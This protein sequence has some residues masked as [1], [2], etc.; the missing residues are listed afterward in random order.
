MH[1]QTKQPTVEQRAA[2]A[3]E[4]ALAN[5]KYV[6]AVDI[7]LGMGLLQPTHVQQWRNGRVDFLERVIQG[8][9]QKRT[10][11]MSTFRQWAQDQGLTPSETAYVRRTR[12]GT[13]D[14]RFSESGDPSVEQLYRTHFVS[15]ELPEAK[16]AKLTERLEQAPKPVVFEIVR[17]SQCSECGV[18]L[19]KNSF[20]LME[21]G[22]PLCLACARLDDL[23]YL[24]AGDTALTRRS[25]K[26]SERTAVVVRFSRS[27]G[28]YER[29][30]ILVEP[31]ALEKAEKECSEDAAERAAAREHAAEF[32][33]KQDRDLVTRMTERLLELFPKCP[34]ARALTIARHTAARG[35]GRVGRSAE[36]RSLEASALTAAVTAAIRH[37]LTNY[38]E[39]L[40]GGM[41][42]GLAR[43]EVADRVAEILDQWRG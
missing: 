13:V 38:D 10:L 42:R 18:E 4:F 12:E 33:A 7:F 34:P 17:D 27:R 35:S 36:G 39:L 31:A 22:Q 16:K 6:S 5:Q 11:A 30:G 14:L 41:D 37:Q 25:T 26:Y 23:E 28:R 21:A 2:R 3:A 15:P 29:Q 1:P 40:F 8:S 24:P 43:V 9:L 32:R 19:Q 20:L